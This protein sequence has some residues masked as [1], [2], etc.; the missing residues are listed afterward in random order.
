VGRTAGD[1]IHGPELRITELVRDG[2][3]RPGALV[4]AQVKMRHPVRTGLA[5]RDGRFVRESEPFFLKELEVL[6]GGE[7]ISRFALTPA[8][9]DDPF[10]GFA[11][12]ARREGRLEVRLSNNRGQR[13]EATQELRFA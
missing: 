11:L 3:L 10:I 6:Y 7:R 13:F 12:L 4:H 2:F 1:D 9:S 8:L 5:F